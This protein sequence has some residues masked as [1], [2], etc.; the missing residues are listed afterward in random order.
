[1]GDAEKLSLEAGAGC[2]GVIPLSKKRG[3]DLEGLAVHI[4]I[5]RGYEDIYI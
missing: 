4:N 2:G 5:K 3:A 1:M